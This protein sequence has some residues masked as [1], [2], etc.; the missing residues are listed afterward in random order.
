VMATC[1]GYSLT[2]GMQVFGVRLDMGLLKL[3]MS[4]SLTQTWLLLTS[5]SGHNVRSQ[6]ELVTE[7]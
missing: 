4:M 2:E 6:M 7:P 5:L 1:E 3:L